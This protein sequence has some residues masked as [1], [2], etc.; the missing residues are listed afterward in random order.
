MMYKCNDCAAVF[1]EDEIATWQESRGEFW[2]F[3]CTE[4]LS[5]CPHCFSG[6]IEEFNEV[7]DDE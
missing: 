7:N 4:T 5:G 3:P 2:G 1:D 6:D